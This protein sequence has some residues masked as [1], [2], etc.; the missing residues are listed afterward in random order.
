MAAVNPSHA[1]IRWLD[2]QVPRGANAALDII[3][4]ATQVKFMWSTFTLHRP[5]GR[6]AQWWSHHLVN[7]VDEG[8]TKAF[9][10]PFG[11]LPLFAKS[12]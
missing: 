12:E 5:T 3:F 7:E 1:N 6:H 9:E 4:R 10:M 11:M 8:G 2:V